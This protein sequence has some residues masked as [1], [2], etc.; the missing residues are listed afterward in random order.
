MFPEESSIGRE[1]R[2]NWAAHRRQSR[3]H[4]LRNS[5]LGP[6]QGGLEISGPGGPTYFVGELAGK[7]GVLVKAP[8][9]QWRTVAEESQRQVTQLQQTMESRIRPLESNINS[10]QKDISGL[11]GS[12]SRVEGNLSSLRSTVGDANAKQ[13]TLAGIMGELS[14]TIT[15]LSGEVD[16]L[17]QRV[18]KLEHKGLDH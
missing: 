10:L 14:T 4:P 16:K 6:G 12:I 15:A 17:K 8:D 2:D 3:A 5:S 1:I 18:W 13:G 11:R 9:G 7:N